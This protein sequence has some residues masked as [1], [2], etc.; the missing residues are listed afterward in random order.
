MAEHKD[1][2]CSTALNSM[3]SYACRV[4]LMQL[5]MQ[6]YVSETL[7]CV[8]PRP[9]LLAHATALLAPWQMRCCGRACGMEGFR[10]GRAYLG[11][12]HR[13]VSLQLRWQS[14]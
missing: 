6:L 3:R 2:R 12:W 13:K 8:R 11:L 5:R 14:R 9:M 7:Y 1:R 4:Q 10:T